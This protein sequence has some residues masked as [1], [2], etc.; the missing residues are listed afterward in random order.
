[1]FLSVSGNYDCTSN[2]AV[3]GYTIN[4]GTP[5]FTVSAINISNV[6]VATATTSAMS[7]TLINLPV[8]TY[9]ILASDASG[10]SVQ[11]LFIITVPFS[12]SNVTFTSSPSC[13]ASNTGIANASIIGSGLTPPYTYT[14]SNGS[15]AQT[16]TNLAAGVYSVTVKDSQGCTVTNSV[17]IGQSTQ[18]I[19][20]FNSTLVP[21]FGG[22]LS[23]AI[24]SSGGNSPYTYSVNGSSLPSNIANNLS[25]GLKTLTT[26]DAN[27]CSQTNTVLLSQVNSPIISFTV[28]KPSCVGVANGS[29]ISSVSAAPPAFS[30][31]WQPVVSFT[32]NIQNIASGNYTLTVKDGSACITQSVVNVTP[33]VSFT[34]SA[35]TNPEN[36]SAADGSA[37]VN[38]SGGNSPYSYTTLLLPATT[39]TLNNLTSGTYTTL[40]TDANNCTDTL[41]F[42]VGNLSTVLVSVTSFTPGQC[43]GQCNGKVQLSTQNAVSPITYSVSGT[44]TTSSSLISNLC[45]GLINI[46]VTDA[47]GCSATTTVFITPAAAFSYSATPSVNTCFGKPI[48]LQAN[49]TGGAGNYTFVWNPGNING[50]LISLTPTASTIYSLNVYDANGC[51]LAPFQVTATINPPITISINNSNS[52]I[53][54]GSTAQITPTISGGDGNYSY[55]WLPGNTVN[56]SIFV[57]NLTIPNYT[58]IVNDGCGSPTA[59][60]IVSINLFPV[61]IPTYMAVNSKGCQPFCTQFKNTTPKSSQAIWNYG[62]KPFEQIGNT[63]NYCYSNSGL[64]NLKLT[65]L[66]SNQCKTSFTYT[67]AINVLASPIANFT[68]IPAQLTLN[69]C[70]NFTLKNTTQNG[71]SFKWEAKNLTFDQG[72]DINNYKLSDTGCYYIKLTATNQNNCSN[73]IEKYICVSEGYN[74][75]MPNCFT[76]NDDNLNEVF[77]PLG[78]GLVSS[79][80]L[81]EVYNRWGSIVFKT[82]DIT[83]G[84]DG[85]TNTDLYDPSNVYFWRIQITDILNE[86]H[87]KSGYVYLLK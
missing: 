29:V 63:T 76:P 67:N 69:N 53:C 41:K 21:C 25:A 58:L 42:V 75:Y 54:P 78:T 19:S 52:G 23:T 18:I 50:Q 84:W 36:C 37:I 8:G 68:T 56:S 47:L 64:F 61:I 43:F 40:V 20:T 26:L 34:L 7:G 77:K 17:T 6:V 22:T 2:Q 13:F 30:Y 60:K 51:T 12:N 14:W 62:D 85:K 70:D 31:T 9:T 55:T 65:V 3:I 39:N 32:N 44:S 57:Q 11:S 35:L 5:G 1:M 33:V 74:F 16:A 71:N 15:N 48:T 83:K 82:N 66:D 79:N 81:F 73:T 24:T 45:S 4:S 27:G 59:T 10:C 72:V 80:Y 86:Y 38:V 46:K 87:L 28:T 49:A